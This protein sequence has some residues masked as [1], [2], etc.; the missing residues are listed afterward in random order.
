MKTFTKIALSIALIS[1]GL[2]IGILLIAGV[3]GSSIRYTPTISL[4]DT[5][6][7]VK[8]LDIDVDLGEV[9]ITSGDDFHIEAKNLYNK[10]DLRSQVI[11]GVWK[12][13]K[14]SGESISIFGFDIPISIGIRNFKTPGIQITVPEGFVAENINIILDAGRLKAKD[15]HANTANFAVDAGSIEIDGLVVENESKYYVGAG[16]INLKQVDIKNIHVECDVGA[17][18][19]EGIISGDNEIQCDVGSIKLNIDDNMDL[20]SF[21]IDSDLGNVIIN[22]KKYHSYSNKKDRNDYKG[23]YRLNVEIGSITMNF[24]EY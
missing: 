13:N 9:I 7:D 22:N 11:N 20:Y 5:V 14:M 8:G 6:R 2:G 3:R 10:E 17:V 15:L 18:I 21:D 19:M 1:I 12:I 4:E 16:Q 23:S 24:S